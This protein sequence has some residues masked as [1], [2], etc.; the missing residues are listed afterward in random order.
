MSGFW[1][2]AFRSIGAAARLARLDRDALGRFTFSIPAF[3]RS[4]GAAALVLPMYL[5]LVHLPGARPGLHAADPVIG[6]AI[7]LVNYVTR[8][9][10]YPLAIIALARPLGL[11]IMWIPYII[12]YNWAQVVQMAVF[13]PIAALAALGFLPL[14][15]DKVAM[16]LLL[17]WVLAYTWI[18]T[19]FA[20]NIAWIFALGFVVLDWVLGLFIDRVTNWLLYRLSLPEAPEGLAS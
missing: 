2:E 14:G 4:F 11:G 17:F 15:L 6:Y 7:E 5:L 10:A 8:W 1:E 20:L 16:T 12:V 9:L 3:R 19:R 13:L 18:I